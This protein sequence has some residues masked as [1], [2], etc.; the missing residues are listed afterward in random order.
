MFKL[1]SMYIDAEAR[2][3]EI[4]DQ[5]GGNDVLFKLHDDLRV[6][7]AER[8]LCRHSIDEL[9]QTWNVFRGDTSLAGRGRP[10]QPRR[11]STTTV[12]TTD[13]WPSPGSLDSMFGGRGA[14]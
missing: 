12:L 14:Y 11:L 4:A 5:S 2:L 10:C 13:R 7:P 8:L 6:A 1:R 9:P 3:A